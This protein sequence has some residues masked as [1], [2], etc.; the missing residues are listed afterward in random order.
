VKPSDGSDY[1]IILEQQNFVKR[2]LKC[3]VKGRR[4]NRRYARDSGG[5]GVIGKAAALRPLNAI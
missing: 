2:A 1:L 3:R 5:P 4:G